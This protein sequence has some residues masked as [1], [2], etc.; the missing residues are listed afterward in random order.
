MAETDSSR[1]TDLA[2]RY[3]RA[4]RR[5]APRWAYPVLTVVVV[6]VGLALSVVLYQNLGS[7]PIEG[8][9]VAFKVVDDGTVEIDLEVARDHPDRAAMCIV[10]ARSRD[11]DEAGRREVLVPVGGDRV[12]VNTVLRTSKRPTTGEVFGCS[13]Q[14]PAYL[15]SEPRPSG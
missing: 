6:L 9:Q 4:G 2:E 1:A 3:G 7:A 10:R 5:K 15:S 14:V 8:K 11:G 12:V 13:Y